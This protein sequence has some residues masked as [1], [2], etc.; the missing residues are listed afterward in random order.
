MMKLDGGWKI[1]NNSLDASRY[2]LYHCNDTIS[3]YTHTPHPR[4]RKCMSN[5]PPEVLGFLKLC[6]WKV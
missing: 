1:K 2:L 3:V 6:R 4:C 5:V